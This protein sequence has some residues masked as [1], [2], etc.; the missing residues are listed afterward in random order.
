M[1]HRDMIVA[2][3]SEALARA[4]AERVSVRL[5]KRLVAPGSASAAAQSRDAYTD[6][7]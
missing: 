6:S 1:Q 5:L 4:A 2:A 7:G 3:E